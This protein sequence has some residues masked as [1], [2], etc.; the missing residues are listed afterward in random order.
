MA[1]TKSGIPPANPADEKTTE[2]FA[3]T[4]VGLIL[5]DKFLE[6]EVIVSTDGKIT[7]RLAT[8][9]EDEIKATDLSGFTPMSLEKPSLDEVC[10]GKLAPKKHVFPHL[11]FIENPTDVGAG[12]LIY[13]D[14]TGSPAV[15]YTPTQVANGVFDTL[16][17]GIEMVFGKDA[18]VRLHNGGKAEE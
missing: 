18:I 15:L 1:H 2:G 8:T 17:A 14:D 12:L 16:V 10:D 7:I 13:F 3:G 11:Y 9:A 5:T 4:Y 6:I